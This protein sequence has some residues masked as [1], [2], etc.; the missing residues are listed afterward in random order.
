MCY[1]NAFKEDS[2]M[3]KDLIGKDGKVIDADWAKFFDE[4]NPFS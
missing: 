4:D 3:D 2:Q 1:K